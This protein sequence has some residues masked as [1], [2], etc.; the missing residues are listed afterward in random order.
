M[1]RWLVVLVA[2][3]LTAAP[4]A[5]AAAPVRGSGDPLN[6]SLDALVAAGAPGVVARV[7]DGRRVRTVA[8][9]VAVLDPPTPIHADGG[10]RVASITKSFVAT[11]VL[12][13]VGERRLR[14]S[15]PVERWLPGLVPGGS[16]I[17][18]RQLLNHTSGIFDI[19]AD[20]AWRAAFLADPGREWSAEELVAWATSHPPTFPPGTDWSYSNTNYLL[21]GLIAEAAT[22]RP[23]PR[24]VAERITR[25]LRLTDTFLATSPRVR[26]G[27][28]HGY[29]P[30]ALTGGGYVDTVGWHPSAAGASGALVSTAPDLARF[31]RALLS[32]RL[33]SPALTRELLTTVP[34]EERD[35]GYGLGIF[36]VDTRCG[37]VWGHSGSFPGYTSIAYQDRSGR[38]SAVL[39][40]ST[41][42]DPRTGPLFDAAVDTA[43]C[44]MFGVVE[45]Q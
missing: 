29:R 14:L 38:R 41:D 40:L 1:R 3:A 18:V 16:A 28:V 10:F 6:R 19:T 5:A 39:L 32:G 26:P 2:A 15:D 9:G 44:E 22:G 30:P 11:V 27:H 34:V 37:T 23:L 35:G 4:S 43:V 12:Q 20:P 8:R 7:D 17:T 24:L 25:P 13:L 42:L 21:V 36:F 31:Y 45:Q 33:L